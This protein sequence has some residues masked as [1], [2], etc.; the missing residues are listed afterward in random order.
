[1][2]NALRIASTGVVDRAPSVEQEREERDP[3]DASSPATMRLIA[4]TAGDDDAVGSLL[5]TL[6]SS[7]S[8]IARDLSCTVNSFA[9]AADRERSRILCCPGGARSLSPRTCENLFLSLSQFEN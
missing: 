2:L 6:L 3:T 9:A 8:P 1:M 7:S 5:L 4:P